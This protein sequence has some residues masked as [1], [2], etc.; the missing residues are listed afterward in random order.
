MP[1]VHLLITGKVQGVYYRASAREEAERLG[2]SGW[3]R[4][5][6]EGHVEAV[7]SGP[8]ARLEE[9]IAWCRQGPPGARVS[10][11]MVSEREEEQF[12]GFEIRRG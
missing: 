11:V 10:G 6:R 3:V 8:S 9:F 1:T 12:S 7:V 5:T 4:N 2:L